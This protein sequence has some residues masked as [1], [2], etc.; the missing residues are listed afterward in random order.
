MSNRWALLLCF[1]A[2]LW[3]T[4]TAVVG[5]EEGQVEMKAVT[6][7]IGG[8]SKTAV[9]VEYSSTPERSAE[10]LL[11]ISEETQ[12]QGVKGLS[13]LKEGDTVVVRY[14]QTSR[15]GETGERI[16]LKTTATSIAL[17]RQAPQEGILSSREG[18][19]ISTEE[20]SE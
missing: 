3:G 6:G 5:Q 19:L 15:K 12:F 14:E 2:L 13:E 4:S 18:A 1:S 20:V 17:V 11:P 9:A 7:V 10:I 8:L 16:V